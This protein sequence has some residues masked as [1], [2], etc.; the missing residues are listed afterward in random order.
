MEGK[1]ATL[2]LPE[3]LK[4][5]VQSPPLSPLSPRSSDDDETEADDSDGEEEEGGAPVGTGGAVASGPPMKKGPWTSDEDQRLRTYVEAHGEGNWNQVQRN[6]GL[7][8]CGK[9]CRLRWA[10]HLRPNLK[11]GPFSKEEE[12]KI[13]ELH[14]LHG[15]KWAKM[16]SVLEGRTDNEI[17]NFW[18]TRMKRLQK[19]GLGLYP[20]GLLS[21]LAN[22][23]M[24]S[25]SPEDSRGKK[26]QNELSQGNGL[27]FDDIIFEKLDYKKQSD[28]FLTPNFTIQDSL[29][30]NDI[31][32]PLKR[33]ASSGIV[34]DYGGS[35]KCE[36][37]SN[38][39]EEASYNDLNSEM[40]VVSF[41]NVISNSMPLLDDNF[42]I[43]G[44]I[45]PIKMELP[46]F[47]YAAYDTSNNLLCPASTLPEQVHGFGVPTKFEGEFDSELPFP[48]AYHFI[49]STSIFDDNTLEYSSFNELTTYKSPTDSD[50]IFMDNKHNAD[51]LH[52]KYFCSDPCATDVSA[53]ARFFNEDSTHSEYQPN[54]GPLNALFYGK[55][56]NDV[57]LSARDDGHQTLL[58]SNG[59]PNT[60]HLPGY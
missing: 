39:I 59:V 9:S 25:H 55:F 7:N 2:V 16:A 53:E 12:Q 45:L 17:K 51:I 47:Q 60:H 58:S 31:N 1:D 29:P 46:S 33:H 10:N 3:L 43:S 44:K 18:N 36:Q 24:G 52:D 42:P 27:E 41:N 34:S 20:D 49:P 13:I 6:A 35:P 37:F 5:E 22:Q 26:R 38:E 57:T 14:A 11:K 15:N 28:N 23:E 40:S 56:C 30:M 32:Y 54:N 8:R 19:A 48:Y 4:E 21:R 50:A